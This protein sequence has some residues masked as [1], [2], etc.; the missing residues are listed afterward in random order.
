MTAAT[1]LPA[2]PALRI[3]HQRTRRAYQRPDTVAERVCSKWGV[4]FDAVA[5]WG[6]T[7]QIAAARR[8]LARQLR[9]C[10]AMSLAEIGAFLGG[11]CHTTISHLLKGDR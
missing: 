8:D 10:T 2:V 7:S 9:S 4:A 5:G 11:R 6:R 3:V 1:P